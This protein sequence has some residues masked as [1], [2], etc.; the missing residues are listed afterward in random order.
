[1]PWQQLLDS[2][3]GV[4]GDMGQYVAQICFRIDTVEFAGANQR[5]HGSRSFTAAICANEEEILASMHIFALC[6]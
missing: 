1:V 3:D 5:I 2:I 6:Q 4:V